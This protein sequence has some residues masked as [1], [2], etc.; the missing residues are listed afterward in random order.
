MSAA[1]PYDFVDAG[2]RRFPWLRLGSALHCSLGTGSVLAESLK[3]YRLDLKTVV[4]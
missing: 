4:T 1:V 3:G 2:L